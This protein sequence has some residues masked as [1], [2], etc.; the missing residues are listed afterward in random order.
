[1]APGSG[2]ESGERQF[3]PVEADYKAFL[4]LV[5]I[6]ESEWK[7]WIDRVRSPGHHSVDIDALRPTT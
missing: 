3:F 7:H 1:M 2:A 4:V 6:N 5:L